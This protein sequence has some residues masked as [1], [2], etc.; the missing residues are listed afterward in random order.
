M[1]H[2]NK[3]A[4]TKTHIPDQPTGYPELRLE[5][6]VVCTERLSVDIVRRISIEFSLRNDAHRILHELVML[7]KD[8][9]E[10]VLF[11]SPLMLFQHQDG[12]M[13]E[14]EKHL[15]PFGS[16]EEKAPSIEAVLVVGDD[17]IDLG[18]I[19][20]CGQ[21]EGLC[22]ALSQMHNGEFLAFEKF[23][24]LCIG[25]E[26]IFSEVDFGLIITASKS[27][28]Q[29]HFASGYRLI[30]STRTD[31]FVQTACSPLTRYSERLAHMKS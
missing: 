29:I 16:P 30:A 8:M 26:N 3:S 1:C 18:R 22:H 2:I 11:Q 17:K 27:S 23:R 31:I 4:R 13:P 7:E 9:D 25:V 21:D 6:C 5:I 12:I 28:H 14:F 10:S 20:V 24:I 15:G 19:W